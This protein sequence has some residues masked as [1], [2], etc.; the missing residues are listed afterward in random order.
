MRRLDLTDLESNNVEYIQFWL[1]SPF[2]DP[3]NPNLDGG[4]LYINLGEIS[5]D[6]LKDGLKTYENGNPVDGNDQFMKETVW[7]RTSSQNSLTYAFDNANTAR[8]IQDT[9]LDGLLN[10]NEF[11]FPSYSDYLD[12]LRA[13]LSPSAIERLQADRFSPFND[14]A[15]DNYHF[16][17]GYDY[18]EERLGILD[19]YNE[20]NQRGA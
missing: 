13:K 15:G 20:G 17:R 16:Y 1:M 8:L 19:P 14:P 10:E 2:L 18:D 12:R 7:G 9:G 4:D 3:E 11:S 5:E 6:I